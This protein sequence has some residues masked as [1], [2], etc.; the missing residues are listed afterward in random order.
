MPVFQLTDEILFPPPEYAEP[1]GLLAIGGDLTSERLLEA[2]SHGIFPWYDEGDPILW[3]SPDPRMVIRPE[4]FHPSKSLHKIIKKETFRVTMDTA[5]EEVIRA[6]S[7][8]PR[9][10]QAGT[11]IT[12]DMLN[13]YIQ[14]HK[15]G[16]GHSVECWEGDTL[17]GGLYGLSIGNMFFGESMFSKKANASKVAFNALCQKLA[18]W[19]FEW[20]DCQLHNEHL[21]SLGAYT[22][23][24]EEYMEHL[25]LGVTQET[26]KGTWVLAS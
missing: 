12:H 6:C 18:E 14:L 20:V 11:W 4:E 3:W 23:S 2:Y 7:K 26:R 22:I 16:Y 8:L 1:E 21:E 5:F 19:K 17:V 15:E 10:N 24:R 25:K 9:K 13:A